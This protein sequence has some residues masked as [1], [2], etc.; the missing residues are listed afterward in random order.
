MTRFL[1]LFVVLGCLVILGGTAVPQVQGIA[2]IVNDEVISRY[3]LESR[4]QL[5][6]F[7]AQM[8][9][10]PE[11]RRRI[12]K[13]V[14]RS[15]IDEHLKLQE[16]KR[17]NI[18]VSKRDIKRAFA[19]IEKRNKVPPGELES[20]LKT[21]GVPVQTLKDQIRAGVAWSKLIGRRLRSRA[22]VSADEV[23]EYLNRLKARQGQMEYRV[24]EILL[25]TDKPGDI[26]QIGETAQRL[27]EQIRAGAPFP[28]VARQFSR[29]A[30]AAVGGDL[31][32]LQ[33]S[34]LDEILK[35]IVPEM[36]LKQITDPIKTIAGYRIVTLL[37]KQRVAAPNPSEIKLDLR[38][39]FVPIPQAAAPED[40]EERMRQAQSVRNSLNGCDDVDRAAKEAAL[41][42]LPALGRLA[43]TDLAPA[44]QNAVADL[45]VGQSS[46]P[47][48]T[49]K[50]LLVL[51]VCDRSEPNS[52]LP[53]RETV[54]KVLVNRRLQMISRR[55]LRDIRLAAVID[56][57]G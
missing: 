24:A 28:A 30:T 17:R 47:I 35:P 1:V 43:L 56:V 22:S 50:G 23:D 7:S 29:S 40:V 21:R 8:R 3:D 20:F 31:G 49:P 2:A 34:E 18:K 36:R 46:A 42:P 11:V 26:P 5:V 10:S 51:V 27:V 38:Q 14:L 44:F 54:R 37:E 48:K 4:T 32:W 15:L 53:D 16:A 55:Y 13:Q 41:P 52:S 9:D 39:F 6:I 57:R 33:E 19:G 25:T 12:L 45:Q